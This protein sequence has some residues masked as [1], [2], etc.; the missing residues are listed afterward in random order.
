[1]PVATSP[2]DLIAADFIE[3]LAAAGDTES[4]NKLESMVST[5]SIDELAE[6]EVEGLER[7]DMDTVALIRVAAIVVS[8]PLSQ[9]Q[10]IEEVLSG[11]LEEIAGPEITAA[12]RGEITG[13]DVP[14]AFRMFQYWEDNGA[15]EKW[16]LTPAEFLELSQITGRQ[17]LPGSNFKGCILDVVGGGETAG[18]V[19]T[20]PQD[21]RSTEEVMYVSASDFDLAV[22]G[23]KTATSRLGDRRELWPV[24]AVI[25]LRSNENE[26]NTLFVEITYN[27][28][29]TLASIGVPTAGTIGSDSVE[30]HYDDFTNVYPGSDEDSA[31][32]VVGFRVL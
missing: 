4:L 2:M 5:L 30:A 21:K 27:Y 23:R 19:G 29:T 12:I 11:I 20:K 3:K 9:P 13:D 7:G 8:S 24:G 26:D 18:P 25:Q 16:L 22:R 28:L 10:G 32:S 15:P 31:L 1:M 17:W 14:I 6:L